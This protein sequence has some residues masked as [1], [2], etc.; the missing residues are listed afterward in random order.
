MFYVIR[1]QIQSRVNVFD[2]MDVLEKVSFFVEVFGF[3]FSHSMQEVCVKQT[4]VSMSPQ[5]HV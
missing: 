3:D 1:M 5:E 4:Y 2:T